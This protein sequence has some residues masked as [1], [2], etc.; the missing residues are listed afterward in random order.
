MHNLRSILLG[1][2]SLTSGI[3]FAPEGDAG[4][5]GSAPSTP[6]PVNGATLAPLTDETKV[7]ELKKAMSSRTRYSTLAEAVAAFQKA[8]AATDNFYGLPTGIVGFDEA[9]QE[10]DSA[11]YEGQNAVLGYVGSKADEAKGKSS[12]VKAIVLYPVP[13]L[14]SILASDEGKKWLDKTAEKEA[15]LVIFRNFRDAATLDEFQAGIAKT[16]K[17][18]DELV[19]AHTREGAGLDTDTFD[20]TWTGM[21]LFLKANQP[22]I[23]KALPAKPEIVKSIRSAS[24][25]AENFEPLETAGVFTKLAQAMINAAKANVDTKTNTPNPLDTS[26]IESWV[27]NRDSLDL[28][29]QDRAA[30][31]YE[32]AVN[33][34]KNWA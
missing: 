13:S 1:S 14:E 31:D 25:A 21:R 2:L 9:T 7:T 8:G 15:S 23:A 33:A 4:G 3:A 29:K 5:T 30:P 12:G 28:K 26:A 34:F 22:A 20:A 18:V 10:I 32:A 11:I 6:A 17:G 19:A 24:Y 16:P 27:A